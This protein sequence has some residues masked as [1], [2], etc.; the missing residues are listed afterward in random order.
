MVL[1]SVLEWLHF[2]TT[3]YGWSDLD[4]FWFLAGWRALPV[5]PFFGTIDLCQTKIARTPLRF[6][7]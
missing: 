6:T 4:Q 2:A 7:Q 5:A 3:K 1:S